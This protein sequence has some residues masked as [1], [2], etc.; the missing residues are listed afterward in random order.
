MVRGGKSEIEEGGWRRRLETRM[1][2]AGVRRVKILA[3]QFRYLGDAVLLT[4][5]LRALVDR[6]P[7]AELHVVVAE[8]VAPVLQHVDW[9]ER[10]WPFPRTRGKKRLRDAWP[11]IRALR[12]ERFQRSVDFSGNDRGAIVSLAVGAHQRLGFLVPGGFLGRRY[13]YTS[14]VA[15]ERHQHEIGRNLALLAAWGIAPLG[16]HPVEIAADPS[17][18]RIAEAMLPAGAILCHLS[19]S[20]PKKEW[21]LLLWAELHRL[22]VS[23]GVELYFSAGTSPREE[24]MLEELHRLAPRA[25]IVPPARDLSTFLALIDN[26]GLFVGCDGA[27]LHFAEAL[28]VPT[29]ALF[30]PSDVAAWAP[31]GSQHIVLTAD[32]C[33]CRRER[34]ASCGRQ[35]PCMSSI[36]PEAV[37]RL[38]LDRIGHAAVARLQ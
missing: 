12:R 10:V 13:C 27:A 4:P 37:L 29:I 2:G 31:L 8:E 32:D 14:T 9:I 11:V 26:A 15:I 5:A 20:Q 24:A 18:A 23:A 34:T 35:P 33:E 30:G 7:R 1:L 17:Q 6:F 21:P 25:A 28:G 38:V 16:W 3:I 36:A 19:T 22:A